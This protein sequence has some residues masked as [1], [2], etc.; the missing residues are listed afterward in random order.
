[1]DH[2]PFDLGLLERGIELLDLFVQFWSL[3]D[4]WVVDVTL[5]SR[6]QIILTQLII[7]PLKKSTNG[8][9]DVCRSHNLFSRSS[10]RLL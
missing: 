8:A 5:L 9:A 2:V 10:L 7:F 3:K 1:M 6:P 4:I